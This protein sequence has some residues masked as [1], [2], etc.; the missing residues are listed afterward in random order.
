MN[1]RRT[2]TRQP[3]RLLVQHQS[4][5]DDT[6]DIDYASELSRGG[7][8]INTRKSVAK[9][10]TLHVQFAPKKDSQLVSAFCRVTHV[11]PQGI[12]AEFVCLDAESERLIDAALA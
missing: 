7:L 11:G 4:S 8:F 6:F 5:T 3:V 10:A 12:G 2:E 9:H 1:E